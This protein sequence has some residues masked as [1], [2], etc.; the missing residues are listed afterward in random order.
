MRGLVSALGLSLWR[1]DSDGQH[2][3][4]L[5]GLQ[6]SPWQEGGGGRED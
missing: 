5:Q 6:L 3:K 2:P 1:R 4:S